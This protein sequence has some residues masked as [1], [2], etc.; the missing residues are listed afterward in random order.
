MKFVLSALFMAFSTSLF[1]Q[2]TV[3]VVSSTTAQ[4][5]VPNT[6]KSSETSDIAINAANLDGDALSADECVK[7]L[8]NAKI[9]AGANVGSAELVSENALAFTSLVTRGNLGDC[10]NNLK[11]IFENS[12]TLEGKVYALMGFKYLKENYLY[13]TLGIT[14]DSSAFVN[15]YLNGKSY[16]TSLSKFL[17]AFERNHYPFMTL[18]RNATTVSEVATTVV[19]ETQTIVQNTTTIYEEYPTSYPVY[20]QDSRP[21]VIVT[22]PPPR[23]RPI[24]PRPQPPHPQPPHPQ[25]PSPQPRPK[26]QVTT[27]KPTTPRPV[28][29]RPP[30]PKPTTPRPQVPRP[31]SSPRPNAN[32]NT[33]NR[34]ISSVGAKPLI[35]HKQAG[36]SLSR[37]QAVRPQTPRVQQA[38]RPQAQRS[39]Q[40]Q[41]AP[42]PQVQR[43]QQVQQMQRPQNQSAPRPQNQAGR[44][45]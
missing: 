27:P 35:S 36:Q 9:L 2:T 10:I 40:A 18:N 19:P 7:I 26:P 8:E 41:Q 29:P 34:S 37:P 17:N 45:M 44:R 3:S 4:A 24:P 12:T 25:P 11:S 13:K 21:I 33:N 14:L 23:P 16:K 20:Y 22:P 15:Y 28:T 5:L 32:F 31:Q 30:N 39:Q 42:R 6:Q 38:S 1:A 43:P